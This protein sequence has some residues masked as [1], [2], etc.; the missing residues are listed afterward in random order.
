VD[1]KIEYQLQHHYS[2]SNYTPNNIH[3]KEQKLTYQK[4]YNNFRPKEFGLH[5]F[6]ISKEKKKN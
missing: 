4:E 6:L 2:I 1:H 5:F 3:R